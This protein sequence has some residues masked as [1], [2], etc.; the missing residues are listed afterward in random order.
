MTASRAA[1]D[2]NA[3]R[4]NAWLREP[5]LHFVV[6]GLLL[7]T[8]DHFMFTRADDPHTIVMGAE[9][10]REAQQVFQ[11]SRGRAPDAKELAAL[12]KVWLD[13][14]VLYREGLAL[15]VDK[16]TPPFANA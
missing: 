12:R 11:A 8:A 10:D 14:E 7:F 15:Q 9:V 3:D 5:L 13:N 16:S 1:S 6:L 4:P 2:N